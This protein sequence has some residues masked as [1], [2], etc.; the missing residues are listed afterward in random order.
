MMEVSRQF[1]SIITSSPVLMFKF[2][3]ELGWEENHDHDVLLASKRK[4]SYLSYWESRSKHHLMMQFVQNHTN[5]LKH[6]S[7]EVNS[8]E[9][10]EMMAALPNLES[11]EVC[12]WINGMRIPKVTLTKLKCL[13]LR[14]SSSEFV[15]W[16][17]SQPMK[18]KYFKFLCDEREDNKPLFRFLQSQ[19]Q[20]KELAIVLSDLKHL[21]KDRKVATSMKFQ[22]K[23]IR[24]TNTGESSQLPHLCSFLVTQKSSLEELY[25]K[26]ISLFNKDVNELL[27]LKLTKLKLTECEFVAPE[28]DIF[29]NTSIRDLAVD[30]CSGS[31]DAVKRQTA[32]DNFRVIKKILRSC[33]A[34][35][36]LE[37]SYIDLKKGLSQTIAAM[38]TLRILKIYECTLARSSSAIT[39]PS[40][41]ILKTINCSDAVNRELRNRNPQLKSFENIDNQ[42]V[43]SGNI[44]ACSKMGCFSVR[45]CGN[46]YNIIRRLH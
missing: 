8:V 30:F 33:Q 6:I 25:L 11:L 16:I 10:F 22:A 37:L 4:Y 20:L 41:K 9:I 38:K 1:E 29:F 12:F 46:T 32:V 26:Q 14:R 27:G 31:S 40:V 24:L 34:V 23:I 13:Y 18:L 21:F 19:D 35:D 28:D 15:S 17:F 45:R 42:K 36:M 5:T 3:V 44:I 39:Y 2:V 7:L 43:E